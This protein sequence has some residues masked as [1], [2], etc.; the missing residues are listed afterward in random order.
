[1]ERCRF[2]GVFC[3]LSFSLMTLNIGAFE[4]VAPKILFGE[5]PLECTLFY[6]NSPE[7]L[8]CIL[9]DVAQLY[10]YFL[11]QSAHVEKYCT[12]LQK[13]GMW[14]EIK[15]ERDFFPSKEDVDVFMQKLIQCMEMDLFR[16][17][18]Y[19][20]MT[21]ISTDYG[22]DPG[23]LQSAFRQTGLDYRCNS[24]LPY[25]TMTTIT[26]NEKQIEVAILLR[27]PYF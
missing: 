19:P 24:L 4:N 23:A 20:S 18:E 27:G 5:L 8:K 26:M 21:T 13:K 12:F 7:N 11:T 1:M 2:K 25:K 16:N 15:D 9:G 6:P 3:L 14:I 10:G 22:P 17:H